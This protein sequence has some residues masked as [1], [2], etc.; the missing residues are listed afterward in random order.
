M[1]EWAKLTPRERGQARMRFQEAKSLPA[2][3]RQAR[4]D[5]YQALPPEERQ[6]LAAR[7]RALA[8][9]PAAATGNSAA[10]VPTPPN[11]AAKPTREAPPQS[12]SNVVPNPAF[13]VSPV[14]I[15]PTVVQ[16]RPGVTTTPISRRPTPPSHQQAG[17]PKIAATP[18]FVDKATLQPQ[19]GPQGAATRPGNASPA[20][21]GPATRP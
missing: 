10:K 20:V 12:K 2:T 13:A 14:P 19:R 15:T 1:A 6:Q 5:A 11:R 3:D 21:A 17:L 9:A 8:A 7:A 18:G 16:A 4:W